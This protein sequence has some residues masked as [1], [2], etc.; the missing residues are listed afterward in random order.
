MTKEKELKEKQLGAITSSE[1]QI[2]ASSL[3]KSEEKEEE[4]QSEEKKPV[5]RESV[6]NLVENM[7]NP[8]S[9]HIRNF[10]VKKFNN[11]FDTIKEDPR[12]VEGSSFMSQNMTRSLFNSGWSLP[13]KHVLISRGHEDES[14]EENSVESPKEP[15]VIEPIRRGSSGLI[16]K[17]RHHTMHVNK[18]HKSLNMRFS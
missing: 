9:R 1:K 4:K 15:I 12:E 7:L 3:E 11:A 17:H 13:P 16:G 8:D 18:R 2:I 5:T 6:P 14:N 10:Q